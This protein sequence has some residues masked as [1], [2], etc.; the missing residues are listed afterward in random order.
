MDVFCLGVKLAVYEDTDAETYRREIR[1]HYETDFEMEEVA[2]AAARKL[3]EDALA[4]ARN[5]GFGPHRD[6]RLAARVFGG[7][8]AADCRQQFQFGREGKPFYVR[9]PRETDTQARLIIEHLGRRC[10][11]GNFHYMVGAGEDPG[12]VLFS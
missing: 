12:E 9:G 7:V 11:A 10:G 2:P 6:Y 8:K 3:V 5:L 4:Y 1:G